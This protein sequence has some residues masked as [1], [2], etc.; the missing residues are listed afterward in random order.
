[1]S[2]AMAMNSHPALSVYWDQHGA[3]SMCFSQKYY[4]VL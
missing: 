2:L 4:H 3:I 1:M